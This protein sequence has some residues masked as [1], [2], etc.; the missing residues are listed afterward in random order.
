MY[1]IYKTR[2]L[3]NLVQQ[4]I[5]VCRSEANG[6]KKRMII[7]TDALGLGVVQS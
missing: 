3:D 4:G 5:K 1:I 2:K 7:E 6:S